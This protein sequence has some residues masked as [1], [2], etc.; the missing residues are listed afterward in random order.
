MFSG[1]WKSIHNWYGHRNIFRC[2]HR[3]Y[4][5]CGHLDRRSGNIP[6]ENKSC[7]L[8]K[9]I[10]ESFP[11]TSID[12][13]LCHDIARILSYFIPF[14]FLDEGI[15]RLLDTTYREEC[16]YNPDDEGDSND[17]EKNIHAS[18]VYESGESAKKNPWHNK[19][20]IYFSIASRIRP[21]R[22]ASVPL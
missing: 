13:Y 5:W 4:D 20:K 3:I 14:S 15:F 12:F 8:A 6:T 1:T 10:S 2:F 18:M 7:E 16:A 19:E 22:V 11:H 21:K 9:S 17:D